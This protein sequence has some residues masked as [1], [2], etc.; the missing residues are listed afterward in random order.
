MWHSAETFLGN[1]GTRF[2][3]YSIRLVLN[4]DKG[5]LEVLDKFLLALGQLSCLFLG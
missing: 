2:A 1:Q 5:S 3:A 4:P